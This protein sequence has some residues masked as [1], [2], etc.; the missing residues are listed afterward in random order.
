MTRVP[1][2]I[3]LC[4]LVMTAVGAQSVAPPTS[5]GGGSGGASGQILWQR[6]LED[7]QALAKALDRPILIA[8]NMD[9]ES[10]SDRIT[11]EI[12]RDPEFVAATRKC[13]C[14]MSSAFRHNLRDYDDDGRR[15]PCPRFGEIT[16]GEHVVLEPI[17][18]KRYLSDAD[19]V[20]PRHALILRNRQKAW[21]LFL[22]FDLRDV[23]T[24]FLESMKSEPAVVEPET[25][26]VNAPCT[27]DDW[28]R[29]ASCR[30]C[31]GRSELEAAIAGCRGPSLVMALDGLR[32][33]GDPGAL[34]AFRVLVA[35]FAD[36]DEDERERILGAAHDLV[37]DSQVADVLR[38][39]V[40]SLGRIPF[41]GL[42]AGRDLLVSAMARL[43]PT[44][45]EVRR[46]V[47]AGRGL[48]GLDRAT[49]AVITRTHDP[50]VAALVDA[51]VAAHGAAFSLEAALRAARS[52]RASAAPGTFPKPGRISDAM[53][54]LADLE[55][56]VAE[57]KAG[58]LAPGAEPGVIARYAKAC[59]DLGR[60]KTEAQDPA[61]DASLADAEAAF[62]RAVAAKADEPDWWIERARTAYF[63]GRYDDEARFGRRAFGLITHG[64]GFDLPSVER[65]RIDD[66]TRR[67]LGDADAV[68]ALRWI[69]DG[70][71]RTVAE[72]SD[73]NPPARVGAIVE[74]SR[75]LA[76]VA[77]SVYSDANDWL[78]FAS[79]FARLGFQREQLAVIIEAGRRLPASAEIRDAMNRALW[80]GGRI[81]L[82]G[83]LAD[84]LEK[85]LGGGAEA[86]WFSG[87]AW[88][89]VAENQ[90]RTEASDAAITTYQKAMDRFA[91]A[92]AHAATQASAR[93][94]TALSWFGRGM[95]CVREDRRDDAAECLVKAVESD[96]AV[97]SGHDGMGC[98]V[99]DL[100]DRIFEWRQTGASRVDSDKLLGRLEAANP[101]NPFWA[102]A[103]AD[104]ELRE[105][106]RADGR[107]PEKVERETVDAGGKPIRMLMGLPT[108][109]GDVYLKASIAAARR[110]RA[111]TD[112]D[113]TRRTLA[114][115]L[116]IWGERMLD[117][118]RALDGKDALIE[119]AEVMSLD[120]PSDPTDPKALTDVAAS[121]RFLL[122][123]ARPKL[124]PRR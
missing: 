33:H 71:A 68:E 82:A 46:L 81:E 70:L 22:N 75:A 63:L 123:D 96:P 9:G 97:S 91:E 99:L 102:V 72:P 67:I 17:I 45:P 2:S 124:R 34:G 41:D 21:D 50:A 62:A 54:E 23:K 13:V 6:S 80:D 15:I 93:L 12:Y 113:E 37:L 103:V 90:R 83:E 111:A 14:L 84:G 48:G 115:S 11:R 86:A 53:P 24:Q 43:D 98:D 32:K 59:L 117:R 27:D 95:A 18:Y 47:I 74:A 79:F 65:P 114:Q 25:N 78:G 76:C 120:K 58:A 20:A 94:F 64:D 42:S 104:A 119:A 60:R 105:A 51:T 26:P 66:A 36:R 52:V 57:C 69:G 116:T 49:S 56:L 110:A 16:C 29:L 39:Q 4:V 101:G 109:E 87:Y 19:R 121:L 10:A 28:A 38:E 89:L 1:L 35:S 3:A 5:A 55:R 7:A 106:L 30:D 85:V 31:K 40:Q 77:A 108:E 44:A 88:M 107:N 118:K 61:A 112:T 122:G 73:D 8:V 92:A 100:T